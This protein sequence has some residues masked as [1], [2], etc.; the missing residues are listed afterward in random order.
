MCFGGVK[1]NQRKTHEE[2]TILVNFREPCARQKRTV[3]ADEKLLKEKPVGEVDP[4]GE[5]R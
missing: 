1:N 4:I 2:R 3:T 5:D